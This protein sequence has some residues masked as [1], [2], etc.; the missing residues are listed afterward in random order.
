MFVLFILHLQQAG[1]KLRQEWLPAGWLCLVFYSL[2]HIFAFVAFH[3]T[4]G[5]IIVFLGFLGHE[6]EEFF[7]AIV[8]I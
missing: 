7:T 3:Y 5:T 4:H 6:L 8:L 1:W 2:P